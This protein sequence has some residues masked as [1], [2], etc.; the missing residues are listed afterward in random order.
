MNASTRSTRSAAARGIVI[1]GIQIQ[2]HS[3]K[4][5]VK[6]SKRGG[7]EGLCGRSVWV[8]ALGDMAIYT[9]VQSGT[10]AQA[11]EEPTWFGAGTVM[12]LNNTI[13]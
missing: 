11:Q 1:G 13:E 9:P 7:E 12:G 5:K 4:G 6:D 8:G 3:G 10:R 2:V